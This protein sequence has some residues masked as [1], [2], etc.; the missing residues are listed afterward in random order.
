[1]LSILIQYNSFVPTQVEAAVPPAYPVDLNKAN[2]DSALVATRPGLA[3]KLSK[4]PEARV[5]D[6]AV[7][8]SS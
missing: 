8:L 5:P 1:M 6:R 7:A 4:Q 2:R 3:V